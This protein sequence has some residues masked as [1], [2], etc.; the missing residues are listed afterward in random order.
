MKHKIEISQPPQFA[1]KAH[2]PA[3]E[4]EAG[5]L[6]F[7]NFFAQDIKFGS[8]ILHLKTPKKYLITARCQ[9]RPRQISGM[10]HSPDP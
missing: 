2:R 6:L 4:S 3:S 5:Y 9:W 1:S 10:R 7:L 8:K